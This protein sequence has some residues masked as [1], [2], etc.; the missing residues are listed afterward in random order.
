M[1]DSQA[2]LLDRVAKAMGYP[3]AVPHDDNPPGRLYTGNG[4]T[5]LLTWSIDSAAKCLPPGWLWQRHNDEF[6]STYK[7]HAFG[8]EGT[9]LYVC[10]HDTGREIT[11]RYTLAA[12]A[13]ESQAKDTTHA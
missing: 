3:T 7:W 4:G 1:T 12:I 5:L 6:T 10:V 8:P 9:D 11:D 2:Q 13:W